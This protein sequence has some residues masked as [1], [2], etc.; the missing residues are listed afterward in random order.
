[1]PEPVQW[2]GREPGLECPE[3]EIKRACEQTHKRHL[4]TRESSV[5]KR[6]RLG[7]TNFTPVRRTFPA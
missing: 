5:G 7:K 1:M 3:E 6:V 4:G 2:N